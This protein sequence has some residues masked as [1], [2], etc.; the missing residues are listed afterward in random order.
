MNFPDSRLCSERKGSDFNCP[1]VSRAFVPE[2]GRVFPSFHQ[3]DFILVLG[4]STPREKIPGAGPE[5]G[6]ERRG[7]WEV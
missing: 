3:P 4:V 6:R 5:K 1:E 2:G 7:F